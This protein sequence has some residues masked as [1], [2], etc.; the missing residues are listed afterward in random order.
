MI[1]NITTK[2]DIEFLLRKVSIERFITQQESTYNYSSFPFFN[3]CKK[4]YSKISLLWR[5]VGVVQP[6]YCRKVLKCLYCWKNSLSLFLLPLFS[7]LWLLGIFSFPK[8][9]LSDW[10]SPKVNISTFNGKI[11]GCLQ[12]NSNWQIFDDVFVRTL[13]NEDFSLH[14]ML[15]LFVWWQSWNRVVP[16]SNLQTAKYI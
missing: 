10:L 1:F 6:L 7:L 3:G 5:L 16:L 8:I 11:K 13:A 12:R 9:C 4:N 15:A 14:E 2:G